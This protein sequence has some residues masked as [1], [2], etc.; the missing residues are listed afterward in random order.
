MSRET[1]ADR[2]VDISA[3]LDGE[4]PSDRT[5]SIAEHL[6]SCDEC[7]AYQARLERIRSSIRL[8]PADDHIPDLTAP[9]MQRVRSMGTRRP[10]WKPDLRVAA[11]AAAATILVLGGV[12]LPGIGRHASVA[13]ASDIAQSVRAAARSLDAYHAT[14]T[15]AERDWNPRVPMRRFR[16]AVWFRAP[17]DAKLRIRDVTEYPTSAWPRNNVTVVQT[18]NRWSIDQPSSCPAA[19]LPRCVAQGASQ[20]QLQTV[21]HRQPFDGATT[22][23]TDIVLPLQTLA[24]SFDVHVDGADV[25]MGRS[26]WKLTLPYRQAAPI[27]ESFEQGGSWRAFHPLDVVNL[28]VDSRSWF[29]LRFEVVAGTSPDRQAWADAN[30]YADRPGETLLDYRT[31]TFTQTAAPGRDFAIEPA[32][33]VRSGGFRSD[34]HGTSSAIAPAYTAG[35]PEYRAGTTDEGQR[36]LAYARGTTWLKVVEEPARPSFPFYASTASQM[37]LQHGWGYY[38]P[39]TDVSPRRLDIYGSATHVELESNLTS[40]SLIDIAN[41]LDVTGGK[42]AHRLGRKSG[43][44]VTR[45]ATSNAFERAPFARQPAYMPPGY[46]ASAALLSHAPGG[47]RTLTVYYRRPESEFDGVGIRLTQAAPVHTLPSSSE[48]FVGVDVGSTRGRWSVESGDLEWID[49]GV[50][51]SVA[52]PSFDLSTALQIATSLR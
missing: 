4:L 25:Q 17:E 47:Q 20:H 32:G 49:H 29:P 11:I 44:V 21:V 42:L 15:I 18:A 5:A 43:S 30:G 1:C 23:P 22:L 37:K 13:S 12:L 28:W 14:F 46:Q 2:R 31:T 16:G 41:S 38:E 8:Q 10:W 33:L 34:A 6:A 39:A 51:R 3:F 26:T 7:A 9:I 35:L 45:V 50:Y 40:D 27:V 24:S 36:V 19:A 48:A 52:L